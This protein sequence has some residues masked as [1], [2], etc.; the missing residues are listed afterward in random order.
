MKTR[1]FFGIL[2]VLAFLVII[3]NT[4]FSAVKS[5]SPDI[6]DLPKGELLF[7]SLSPSGTSR[8]DFYLVKNSIGSAIRGERVDGNTHTNIYWETGVDTVNAFWIDEYGIVINEMPLNVVSHKFDSRRGTAIFSEG[9][10]AEQI[11]GNE[12]E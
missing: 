11:I 5:L 9:S 10:T 12:K 2:Y 7:S 8:V 3:A 6:N 4:A 1:I